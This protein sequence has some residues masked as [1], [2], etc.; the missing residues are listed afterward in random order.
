VTVYR[1]E[2]LDGEI[3]LD[4]RPKESKPKVA[5]EVLLRPELSLK[6]AEKKWTNKPIDPTV[7]KYRPTVSTYYETPDGKAKLL[8][9]RDVLDVDTV[10]KA[11]EHMRNLR[12]VSVKGSRRKCLRGSP[13]EDL[14]LGYKDELHLDPQTS[15][16]QTH[17]QLSAPSVHQ[18]PR[19]R[20][21]W[22]LCWEMEDI[23]R[24]YIP[25]Y[26]VGREIDDKHGPTTRDEGNRSDFFMQPG[27]PHRAAVEAM[28]DWGLWYNIPGSN[29]TTITVNHN[30][31]FLA[32]K[33]ANNSS[34]ALSCMAAFRR[35]A[36]GE[37]C[38]PR[39]GV[40]LNVKE[41]DMLVCDCPQELHGTL[42]T[43][44]GNRYTVVTYTREGLTRSG[45]PKKKPTVWDC[46]KGN[47]YPA[48]AVYV[49]C[50]VLN[51]KG[52]VKREASVFGN[53]TNP[54]VSHKGAIHSERQFR[55]YA[56]E[57][58]KD[59][60]FRAEAE[61][62]RGR[63]LL[64]WCVQ[65]GKRRAEF[66]HARVWLKL[67]N[68]SQGALPSADL[69]T[70]QRRD[71]DWGYYEPRFLSKEE[72]DALF[73]MAKAQP[74][75][76]PVIKRSGHPLRRC[77][78]TLWSVRDRNADD[79]ELMVPLAEAPPEIVSLQ[80]KLSD[81]A[82]KGVNYFSLQAYE[83]ERDHIGWHQH[84]EDK[85]RDARVF[86]I[87]LGERRSFGVDKLCS[88]CLLCDACNQR[89]CHPD[90]PPCS[91]YAKCRAAKEHRK[92]C[93]VRKSTKTVLLPMHGSLIALTSEA[94]DWYEHAVLDD[95]EFKGLRISINTKCIPPEDAAAGYVPR[96]FRIGGGLS[97]E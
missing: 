20:G 38:F 58:L 77:A 39:L 81:L 65:E 43:P 61:K 46:H 79:S 88:E 34:G 60:A 7:V 29:F 82:G 2:D 48:D 56:I 83:N 96:E 53:G 73:E 36:G 31:R 54:L 71:F 4:L 13:G 21:L 40:A 93:A 95:K 76:R 67:I 10:A 25:A 52:E 41:R 30:T 62:L 63:D 68:N 80:R 6:E 97:Q 55:A 50:R 94:N 85:C 16:K 19:F 51:R 64:C 57:K 74:R 90:G 23:L 11:W 70:E 9:L 32:H 92:T 69:S 91:N 8:F 87:S 42:S 15:R 89:R 78:S 72:A 5:E 14:L 84:R 18:F 59:P 37:L 27:A 33:D 24:E 28:E 75:Y 66:C 12:M 44:Q 17:P 49:G 35:F 22:P 45:M 3:P 1:I 26:W 86:I 47:K